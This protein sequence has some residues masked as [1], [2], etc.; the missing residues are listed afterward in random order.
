M[1]KDSNIKPYAKALVALTVIAAPVA[2]AL[3]Q[4][5]AVP[6]EVLA[7]RVAKKA[8]RQSAHKKADAKAQGVQLYGYVA[9]SDEHAAGLY[10]FNTANPS[11]ISL[12]SSDVKNYG[13]GTYMQGTFLSSY[14]E[15]DNDAGATVKF[16]VHF[17]EYDSTDWTLKGDKTSMDMAFTAISRDLAFDPQ[18]QKVYGIFSDGNYSGKYTT[19]GKLTY[20]N[21]DSDIITS[22]SAIGEL[23]ET[24]IAITFNRNGDLY[25]IGKSGKLYLVNK[26]NATYTTIGSTGMTPVPFL[27]QSATCDYNTGKIYWAM[28]GDD[29]ATHIVEIDPSTAKSTTVTDFGD[30]GEATYDQMSSIFIKQDL[31][32]AT[33]P[34]AASNLSVSLSS[35]NQGT[36][37]FTMPTKDVNDA[38]LSGNLSYTLRLNGESNLTGTAAPGETVTREFTST[39]SGETVFGVTAEVPASDE[40]PAAVSEMTTTSTRLGYD[41]PKA[42]SNLTASVS[43]QD[44]KLSWKAPTAGVNGGYFDKANINYT[45]VRVNSQNVKDSVVLAQNTTA[46]AYT[47]HI[48]SPEI[49]TYYYKVAANNGD[50]QSKYAESRDVNVGTSVKLPY[51]NSIH[52][53][54]KFKELTVVDANNDGKT[55]T[56]SDDYE[57]AIYSYS[58][59]NAGDDWLISPAVNMKKN[60]AYKFS[61]DAVNT[62]PTERVAASVGKAATAEAMTDEVIAPTDITYNPRRHTLSGTFRAKEDG[63]H[64][65]GVHAVS[66]A[67]CNTLFVDNMNISEVPATAPDVVSELNVVPG[68][69]GATSATVSFKAPTT[70]LD[71]NKLTGNLKVNIS[72]D[73]NVVTTLQNIAPGEACS[74]KDEGMDSGSH[75]YAVAAI[76]ANGEEGLDVS[77]KVF[78]GEDEPGA[79]RNLKAVEDSEKEG[80][81]HVTWDAPAGK[82]GGYINPENLTYYISVGTSSEDISLGNVNK[83]DEQL[84]TNGKQVY[85]G[86]SVYAVNNTG[87]GRENWKTCT[88]IAGP[89][90]KAPMI[91]SFPKSTMKSGPWITNVTNGEIGEA[92]CYCMSES[93]VAKPQDEDGGM[94]SFG[95]EATGKAVRSESP[96]VDISGME[97]P[98]LNFWVYLNGDGDQMNVSIQKNYGD[99]INVKSI[100]SDEASKG[101]HRYSID[102]SPYKDSKYIRV[103]FEGKAVKNTD[104]FLAYDNVAIVENTAHDLMATDLTVEESVKAGSETP[105]EFSFRNNASTAVKGGDYNIVLYKNDKEVARKAGV[106]IDADMVKTVTIKNTAT[107][108]DTEHTKYH[109][110]VEYANDEIPANNTSDKK[111][112]KVVLPDY[113]TP[114]DLT[115][116]SIWNGVQLNWTAPELNDRKPKATVESF[117]DY[118]AFVISGY[119]NWTTYDADKQNTIQITL[120]EIFGPL[121]Y[122]NAGKPMAF[123]VFNSEKAGIP[124]E[125]WDAHTG[126]QMLVSFSC[127]STD[128]GTT[129][130]QNDDWLISPELNGEAQTISFYAKAGMGGSALPEQFEVLYST[131]SKAINNFQKLGSTVDVNNAK[132]WDEYKFDLPEGAK[133]FAIRCVSNNKFALLIDDI[134]FVEAGSKPEDLEL[135]GYN[136]YR[137]GVKMN[138]DLI[139]RE[140]FVDKIAQLSTKYSYAVTAL[141]DKGESLPSNIAEITYFTG[142]KELDAANVKVTTES[143]AIVIAGAEGKL[144]SVFSANGSRVAERRASST[145]HV[146]VAP[147]MYIVR[148]AGNSYKVVVK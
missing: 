48:D 67:D 96:K 118:N 95:A 82:N 140:M 130:A 143:G 123:Q 136:V 12:V 92:Y 18:T 53:E 115:A 144:A 54:D 89:A 58:Q 28:V 148:V 30:E 15:E 52:S 97:H 87:G 62:Y 27:F 42:P 65:F 68:E 93:T 16:P 80:L 75:K 107:V 13:G 137:D 7:R 3:A 50:M 36:V 6:A 113:P 104:A 61:F 103:G 11:G 1:K 142:V 141:Y 74:Y 23:P 2:E 120:S 114:T 60:S 17:Y 125:S 44:V 20:M 98:V 132:S 111:Q 35:L 64:Y 77:T 71:G 37:T 69:N 112:I 127:A 38:A 45:V 70:A 26:Y 102:L 66:D 124:Y 105:V 99:F 106:D 49:A 40:R 47:D 126:D 146:N 79:V 101:W 8:S 100:S 131:T 83:Y 57:A 72:R 86:Y 139:S 78:V 39:K 76:N 138:A 43:G 59:E 81:I 10:T 5:H 116:A 90:L 4:T 85:T 19:L 51:S 109:A 88:A 25:C 122:D 133:Y 145:E 94:Q 84:T 14:Y 91:E 117:E 22:S 110:T 32:L 73:G 9:S 56:Y 147:G 55:W 24:I 31:N 128:G 108:F 134:S 41:V 63:L 121:K 33:L 21:F 129:K 119:G 46:T 34:Q 135:Q 29:W